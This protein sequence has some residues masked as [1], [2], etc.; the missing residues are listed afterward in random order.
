MSIKTKYG[1]AIIGSGGYYEIKS[2]KEGNRGKKLHR[3]IWEDFYGCKIPDGY[4]IHHR[5]HIKTDNCVLNLQLMHNSDHSKLHSNGE[6]NSNY[7]PYATVVK[8]G[9]DRNGKQRYGINFNGKEMW[10]MIDKK[11]LVDRF[12]AEYPLEIIKR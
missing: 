3:L 2:R 8:K 4:V 7:K 5:N 6:N 9:F 12:C 10:A 1:T 11:K